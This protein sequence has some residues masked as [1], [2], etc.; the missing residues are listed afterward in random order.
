MINS[1]DCDCYMS[2]SLAQWNHV[3]NIPRLAQIIERQSSNLGVVGSKNVQ[4]RSWIYS[5]A[6]SSNKHVCSLH[7]NDISVTNIY[8]HFDGTPVTCWYII[9]LLWKGFVCTLPG[10]HT[11]RVVPGGYPRST[12]SRFNSSESGEDSEAKNRLCKQHGYKFFARA[13]REMHD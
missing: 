10:A 12:M 6:I 1:L 2:A 13:R 11:G 5:L 4:F 9:G 7:L 3:S 8:L